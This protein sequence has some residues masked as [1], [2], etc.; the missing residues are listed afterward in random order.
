LSASIPLLFTLGVFSSLSPCFFPL[1][2]SFLTYVANVENNVRKGVL[3]GIAC[4]LGIALSF[5][6]YGVFAFFLFSPLTE[7]GTLL[8]SLFGL[9]IMLLG[10]AM[11]TEKLTIFVPLPQRLLAFK[12]YVGAF[13]LGLIYTLI[14]APCAMP[15]LSSAILIAIIPDNMTS[16]LLNLFVLTLGVATPFLAASLCVMAMK[17]FVENQYHAFAKWFRPLSSS[18]LVLTG[19]LLFLPIFGLPSIFY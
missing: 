6:L 5:T 10:I 17:T 7:Y 8:R 14:A 18:I 15:I 11:F 12:G 19:L 13:I 2:P 16:T 1:F 9:V 3:A 4:L